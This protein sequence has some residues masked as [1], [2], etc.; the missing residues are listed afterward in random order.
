MKFKIGDKVNYKNGQASY[1]VADMNSYG[2]NLTLRHMDNGRY[3][4]CEDPERLCHHH[5]HISNYTQQ[6]ET[7]LEVKGNNMKNTVNKLNGLKAGEEKLVELTQDVAESKKVTVSLSSILMNNPLIKDLKL[8]KDALLTDLRLDNENLLLKVSVG[9][10]T[11]EENQ[12]LL[13]SI[14]K[15]V[16]EGE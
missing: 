11:K 16:E 8:G 10:V 13:V 15:L 2:R 1:I 7:G 6:N 14:K 4:D 12:A 3:Y 5:E 9:Q